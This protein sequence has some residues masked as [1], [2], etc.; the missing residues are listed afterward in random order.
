MMNC[1]VILYNGLLQNYQIIWKCY[2]IVQYCQ[3]VST[4]K[5]NDFDYV[6]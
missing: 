4:V 1:E 5:S 6:I 3:S 2:H